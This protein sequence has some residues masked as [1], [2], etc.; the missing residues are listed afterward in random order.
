MKLRSFLLIFKSLIEARE[1]PYVKLRR[2]IASIPDPPDGANEVDVTRTKGKARRVGPR[3]L[4]E[5]RTTAGSHVIKNMTFHPRAP[6]KT[7]WSDVCYSPRIIARVSRNRAQDFVK[8]PYY[9]NKNFL[10]FGLENPR[11]RL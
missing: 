4:G 11:R 5:T 9:N 10:D 6:G 7:R 3:L 1:A 2:N 8:K